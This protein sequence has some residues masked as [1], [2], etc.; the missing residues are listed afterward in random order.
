MTEPTVT[1]PVGKEEAPE[2]VDTSPREEDGDQDVDQDADFEE[3]E[4]DSDDEDDEAVHE[5]Y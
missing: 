4:A 3:T 5:A 2:E 1:V